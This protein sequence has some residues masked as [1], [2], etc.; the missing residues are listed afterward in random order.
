MPVIGSITV[1]DCSPELKKT[2][3]AY[4]ANNFYKEPIVK[5]ELAAGDSKS[6]RNFSNMDMTMTCSR[7]IRDL[8]SANALTTLSE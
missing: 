5:L 3:E 1:K 4:D 7:T 6:E 2:L 8:R